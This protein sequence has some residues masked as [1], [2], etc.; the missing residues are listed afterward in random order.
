MSEKKS[1]AQ[2]IK[3]RRILVISV[4]LIVLFLIIFIPAMIIKS[5]KGKNADKN[6]TS[7]PEISQTSTQTQS[8][9]YKHLSPLTGLPDFKAEGNRPIAFMINNSKPARPQWGLCT[10]DIVFEAI[11]EGGITRMLWLYADANDIPSKIGSMRSA[12]HDFV[13]ISEGMDALFVHWGGSKYA[14][15]SIKNRNVEHLDGLVY[16]QKLFFRDQDR[17]VAAEH[18][19]YTSQENVLKGFKQRNARTEIKD[20]YTKPF[21]FNLPNKAVTPSSGTCSKVYFEFSNYCNHSFTYDREKS[22]YYNYIN[23]EPMKDSDGNHMAVTNV[24]LLYCSVSQMGDDAGCVDMDLTSGKGIYISN[25]GYENISWEKGSPSS[26]LK[27]YNENND[28][29]SLNAG[30][31]YI[32]FIPNSRSGATSISE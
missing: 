28:E 20:K 27:L 14:Y 23:S 25:G 12:R 30:K 31:S 5:V 18:R 19:G 1:K 2:I 32:A 22:L 15:D 11:T 17:N 29:L 4:F 9:D 6:S 8:A 16:A 3:Q 10:P 24:I 13:E 7:A 26:M 21:S